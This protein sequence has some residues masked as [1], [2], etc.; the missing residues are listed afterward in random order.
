MNNQRIKARII[1]IYDPIILIKQLCLLPLITQLRR[2][3]QMIA[4]C[5]KT[6]LP[7]PSSERWDQIANN[8]WTYTY[9]PYQ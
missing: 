1:I 5:K 3:Q 4:T 9:L 6:V 7:P 2:S 8:N